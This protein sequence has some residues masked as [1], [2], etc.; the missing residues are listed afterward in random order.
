MSQCVIHVTSQFRRKNLELPIERFPSLVQ[1]RNLI[2]LQ[3]LTIQFPLRYLSSGRSREVQN[4]S[5][6]LKVI[7]VSYEKR[8]S[9]P[10]IGL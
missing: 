8:S 6:R 9:E 1:S 5:G 2:M 3:H 7:A 4:K 10:E